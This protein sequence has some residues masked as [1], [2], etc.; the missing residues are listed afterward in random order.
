[1]AF[2]EHLLGLSVITTPVILVSGNPLLAYNAAFF[3]SFPFSARC[4]RTS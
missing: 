2:S 1:M 3:L 4:R